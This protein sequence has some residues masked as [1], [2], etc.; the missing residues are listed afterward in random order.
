D[1]RAQLNLGDGLYKSGKFDEAQARYEA[2]A[3]DA[4]SP[5]AA[6][7]RYNLGNTLFQK[8]D[9]A[10]AARAYRDALRLTPGD[11]DTRH[12]LEMALRAQQQQ[13]Q[14]QQPQKQ[15]Q[16][17]KQDQKDKPSPEQ[18]KQDQKQGGQRPERPK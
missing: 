15:K 11:A 4:R 16:Q 7:A 18:K 8:Q 13:Q 3:A 10:G 6:S 1:P 5:L 14:Q 2:L 9:Y 12:N 17:D